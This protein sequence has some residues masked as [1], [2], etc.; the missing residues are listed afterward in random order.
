MPPDPSTASMGAVGALSPYLQASATLPKESKGKG[1]TSF[2]MKSKEPISHGAILGGVGGI[3]SVLVG[4]PLDTIKVRLQTG[5]PLHECH[6]NLYRGMLSPLM[7]VVP[8]WA[9]SYFTYAG[10][11]KLLGK[12]SLP[13]VAAAG[14]LSGA[15]YSLLMCP[16]DYFKVNSQRHR[17]SLMEM[18][19]TNSYG[20]Q[21]VYRGLRMAL[22]RDVCQSTAYYWYSTVLHNLYIDAGGT[23]P[24]LLRR[25]YRGYGP[26]I[27]RGFLVHGCGFFVISFVKRRWLD[28]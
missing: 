25:V 1:G 23:Y 6:G 17:I 4:Y 18:L 28:P 26:W 20:I 19:S 7:A 15:C 11:L 12:D 24:K 16:F 9:M 2:L 13:S 8:G 14:A 27:I 5:V 10:F 3:V 22:V 21:Q